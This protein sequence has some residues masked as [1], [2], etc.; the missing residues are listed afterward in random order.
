[1]SNTL[2]IATCQFLVSDSVSKNAAAIL[3]FLKKANRR[4]AD[5][6]HFSEC[7]LSGYAGP[8]Y[9]TLDNFD[10]DL[11]RN[12][13]QQI[14]ALA[15]Q[16]KIWVVLPS[17]HRL[18]PPNKPHNSLYIINPAGQIE[19]RYD[20]RFC[21]Q[22]DLDYYSPGNRFVTFEINNVKCDAHLFRSSFSGTLQRA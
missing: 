17:M 20:K 3:A 12:K 21:T 6:V 10:W 2:K 9:S 8:N 5:I 1:M 15:S 14:M 11:L 22:S 16:L 4:G 18:T 7:T 13:T 19:N